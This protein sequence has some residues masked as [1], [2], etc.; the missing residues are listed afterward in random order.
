M[1][2]MPRRSSARRTARASA[3]NAVERRRARGEADRL[4]AQLARASPRR[5]APA[6]PRRRPPA[7]AGRRRAARPIRRSP[8]AARRRACTRQV[9]GE[10]AARRR[11]RSRRRSPPPRSVTMPCTSDRPRPVP[12]PTSLVVKNGSK[13]R[14]STSG[15]MPLPVSATTSRTYS[16]ASGR[17]AGRDR[18]RRLEP[19]DSSATRSLPAGRHRLHGVGAQV[20]HH[21]VHLR[22]VAEHRRRR[23]RA[24][25]RASVHAA[26]AASPQPR[27]APRP[28]PIARGPARARRRRCG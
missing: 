19:T 22:R 26:A 21:L 9:D 12:T 11:P 25:V 15:A 6:A 7:R 14:S 3:R 10:R 16:A 8:P 27:R 24:S 17:V 20:H 23:R 1:P 28:R 5:A 18:A 2:G 4:V 13:M